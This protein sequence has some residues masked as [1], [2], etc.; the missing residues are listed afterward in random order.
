V[1]LSK[2][3]AER[4]DF[5]KAGDAAMA[6][7]KYDEAIQNY[8]QAINLTDTTEV[9]LLAQL[10]ANILECQYQSEMAAATAAKAALDWDAALKHLNQAQEYK[11]TAAVKD[12]IAKLATDKDYT[13]KYTVGKELMG[14]KKWIQAEKA[15]EEAAKVIDTPDVREQIRE[16]AYQ[17]QL[18]RGLEMS[19][20]LSQSAAAVSYLENMA[21]PKADEK[22]KVYLQGLIQEIRRQ[23]PAGSG[24]K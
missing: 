20:D 7:A 15:F 17:R 3:I 11:D 21:L 8:K 12:A 22:E 24:E 23:I 9:K 1:G 19:K 5:K 18:A 16:C 4:D 13:Q 2:K 6:K 10:K 14:Q